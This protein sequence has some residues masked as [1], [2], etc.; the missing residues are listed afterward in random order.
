M[1]QQKLMDQ[2][3][4]SSVSQGHNHVFKKQTVK[5][6]FEITLE[7]LKSTVIT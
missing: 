6:L 7:S 5:G 2:M 4:T 1:K 3:V